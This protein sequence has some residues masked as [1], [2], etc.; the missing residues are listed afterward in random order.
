[1]VA[2][3]R[4]VVGFE[5][6]M[7]WEDPAAPSGVRLPADFLGPLE[8]SGYAAY[9]GTRMLELGCGQ[10]RQWAQRG[11]N[12]GLFMSV[13]VGAHQVE[14]PDFAKVVLEIVHAAGI[15]PAQLLIDLTDEALV[16][17]GTYGWDKL[18]QLKRAGVRLGLNDFGLGRASLAVLREVPFDALRLPAT[19][20]G[21][22]VASSENSAIVRHATALAHDLGSR[23]VAEGVERADQL[24]FV[25]EA[26]CDLAQ[27]YLFGAPEPGHVLEPRL[28][29]VTV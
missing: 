16:T 29:P 8:R 21:D 13:N 17:L 6:L 15:G 22:A 23:V 25:V 26:G 20:V 19:F 14:Q 12:P 11:H 24:E 18:K 27:G 1:V 2:S 10:L 28:F 7:R 5:A 4:Q 9:V 3:T